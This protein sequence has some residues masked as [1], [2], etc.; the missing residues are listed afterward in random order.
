MT[1]RSP[2]FMASQPVFATLAGSSLIIVPTARVL[3]IGAFE[4][5]GVGGAGLQAGDGHL[6]VLE[7][8]GSASA[9][10]SMKA[11]EPL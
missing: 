8:V 10:L 4:E 3:E 6:A 7:L 5:A 1:L 11:L 2:F 9:K